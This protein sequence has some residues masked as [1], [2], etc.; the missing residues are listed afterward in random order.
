MKNKRLICILSAV[1][2]SFSVVALSVGFSPTERITASA[3]DPTVTN[4]LGEP[5]VK[6]VN[7]NNATLRWLENAQVY[8]LDVGRGGT[9]G[10]IWIYLNQNVVLQPGNF[11]FVGSYATSANS[12]SI[13]NYIYYRVRQGSTFDSGS[14]IAD[15]VQ[16]GSEFVVSSQAPY[17]FLFRIDS[18]C[19]YGTYFFK[20]FLVSGRRLQYMRDFFNGYMMG[21]DIGEASGAR[22]QAEVSYSAGYNDG[23]DVGLAE[24]ANIT[25]VS[26]FEIVQNGLDKFFDTIIIP[27]D[28]DTDNDGVSDGGVSIGLLVSLGLGLI[29]L[30]LLLRIFEG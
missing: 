13:D 14:I 18:G 9:T 10:N 5:S 24:G 3:F 4:L 30:T 25:A 6:L 17:S 23:Y 16:A 11:T 8:R 2:L 15:G 12:V 28:K 27:S 21:Y 1:V 7:S 22:Q 19:P 26:P 20:P 29:L